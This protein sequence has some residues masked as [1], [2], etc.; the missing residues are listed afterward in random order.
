MTKKLVSLRMIGTI[1]VYARE[2]E[3]LAMA[4]SR[5]IGNGWP[6]DHPCTSLQLRKSWPSNSPSARRRLPQQCL[7]PSKLL[8]RLSRLRPG[9]SRFGTAGHAARPYPLCWDGPQ[10]PRFAILRARVTGGGEGGVCGFGG[11]LGGP[12]LAHVGFHPGFLVEASPNRSLNRGGFSLNF[13]PTGPVVFTCSVLTGGV[14]VLTAGGVLVT[15]SACRNVSRAC[16]R[17]ACFSARWS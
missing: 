14:S 2:S 11:F 4:A 12:P 9:P 10:S 15:V 7:K 13:G 17:R 6:S 16:S 5:R 8:A 1:Q 3:P